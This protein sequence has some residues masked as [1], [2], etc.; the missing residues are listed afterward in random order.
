MTKSLTELFWKSFT[1][2][3]KVHRGQT[4]MDGLVPSISALGME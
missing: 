1:T 3:V 2:N 4:I